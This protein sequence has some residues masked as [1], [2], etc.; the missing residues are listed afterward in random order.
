MLGSW[1]LLIGAERGKDRGGVVG[2]EPKR[3]T[4]EKKY[5]AGKLN[6]RREAEV[7]VFE[8]SYQ[9]IYRKDSELKHPYSKIVYNSIHRIKIRRQKSNSQDNIIKLQAFRQVKC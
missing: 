7:S 8:N 9:D 1:L 4:R 2:R 6:I 3:A 5:K